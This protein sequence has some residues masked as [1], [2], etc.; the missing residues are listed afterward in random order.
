MAAA[1]EARAPKVHAV[2][3]ANAVPPEKEVRSVRIYN[4]THANAQSLSDILSS[5]I[6]D[7]QVTFDSTSNRI[8]VMASSGEHSRLEKLIKELD[9]GPREE[10]IKVFSLVN[11]EASTIWD[12]ISGIANSS[13]VRVAVDPRTNSLLAAGSERDLSVIEAL[14]MKLDAQPDG[15]PGK[16]FRV[17]IVWFAEGSAD[18]EGV[19]ADEELLV[20]LQEL[21]KI[22]IEGLR[23]M[24]QTIVSTA[25][26]GKF[27]VNC[28]AMLGDGASDLQIQGN[29]NLRQFVP[30]LA[31]DISAERDRAGQN[32][33]GDAAR[34][35]RLVDLSTEIVAPLGHYVVLGITPTEAKTFAFAVQVIINPT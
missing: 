7:A 13:N 10:A 23:P 30:Y 21:S 33:A 19:K 11:V 15:L 14:L 9:V 12:V 3:D 2:A 27:Q 32:E 5:V 17:R 35:A 18:G 25:A 16:T 31:I 29:L 8:V 4:V 26:G 1:Q 34:P 24:G 22:G 20:V 28:S 6:P